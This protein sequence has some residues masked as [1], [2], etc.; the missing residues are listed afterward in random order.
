MA[1]QRIVVFGGPGSGA[2]V[3]Q[4]IAALVACGHDVEL[5]GFLNDK[6]P[7]G[8]PICGAPVLGPF[9]SWRDLANDVSFMAPLHKAKEMRSRADKIFGWQ[10]P[11]ERWTTIIDPRSAV[12]HDAVIAVNCFIAPFATV[13]SGAKIG[14]HSVVRA[15]A[16]ISHDCRLSAFVFVGA[17]AVISG[18]SVVEDGAHIAPS[19]SVSER[20]RVGRYAVV[21]QGA[22]V[23]RDVPDFAVVAGSPAR[24]IGTVEP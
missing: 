13:A 17:N 21:G 7:L 15:G 8:E 3:A 11:K 6:L 4:S 20:C 14:M 18:F 24:Q 5:V 2:I 10:I 23:I 1:A 19:A 9:A 12:A 16:H 22:V